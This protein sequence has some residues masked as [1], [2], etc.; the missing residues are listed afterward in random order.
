MTTLESIGNTLN[1]S[2][3]KVAEKSMQISKQVYSKSKE[4]IGKINHKILSK[5]IK[6]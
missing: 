2:A 5:N 4:E 6:L 3:K 1:Y